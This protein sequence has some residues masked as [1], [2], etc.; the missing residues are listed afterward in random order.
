[1]NNKSTEPS[2]SQDNSSNGAEW[3][4]FLSVLMRDTI[5]SSHRFRLIRPTAQA[6]VSC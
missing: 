2:L 4:S 1:M 3:L 5:Q 6:F